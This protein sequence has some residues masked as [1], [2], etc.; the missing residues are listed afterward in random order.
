MRESKYYLYLSHEEVRLII[1]V[2]IDKRNK[3]VPM[4]NMVL[5]V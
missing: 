1:Q 4:P 3:L 5:F 2:L